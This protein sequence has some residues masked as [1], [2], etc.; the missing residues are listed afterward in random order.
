M[1][2]PGISSVQSTMAIKTKRWNDPADPDDGFR[3]LVCRYRPRGVSKSDETW[4][5]WEPNLGPTKALLAAFKT[6]SAS[7]MNWPQ[8]RQRY[9]AEMRDQ[10]PLIEALAKRVIKGETI[11]LLCTSTC[12][13][14]SRCHRSLLAGLIEAAVAK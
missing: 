5:A 1:A 3:L 8:Y 2:Q 4:N 12:T 6:T 14:E 11:T 7:P 10:K 9:I 13:R